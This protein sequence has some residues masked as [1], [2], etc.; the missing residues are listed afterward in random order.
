MEFEREQHGFQKVYIIYILFNH[1]IFYFYE[2]IR[3]TQDVFRREKNIKFTL[4]QQMVFFVGLV[5]HS[6]VVD[7]EVTLIKIDDFE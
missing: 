6:K 1:I 3:I 2:N 7:E 5:G 4:E